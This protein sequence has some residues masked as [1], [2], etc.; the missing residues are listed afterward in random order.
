[1]GHR[2]RI[3]FRR[4]LLTKVVWWLDSSR[5]WIERW[6]AVKLGSRFLLLALTTLLL[7]G[8]PA[9][10]QPGMDCPLAVQPYSA[11]TIV[12]DLLLNPRTRAVIEK[13]APVLVHGKPGFPSMS[14]IPGFGTIINLREVAGWAAIP[15]D[16]V[17]RIDQEVRLI[18]VTRTDS[19]ER[20][21]RYDQTSPTLPKI[22]H[23]PAFLVF[24]KIVGFKDAPSVNAA[25]AALEAMAARRGWS[26]VET[27]NAAVFNKDALAN[28]DAV[29][30]NNV[31]GDVLTVPQEEAFKDYILRGG[32]FAGFHGSGGDPFYVW[33]WYA[34]TLIGARFLGHP[35][36]PQFQA[37]RVVVDDQN[38]A[39]VNGLG[40]GWTMTEEWYSFKSS[41]RSRGAHI[42]ARLDESTYSPG[43]GLIM[44]DHPI[45]WTQCLGNGR[46]FYTAIGHMP[47]N[48]SESHS[49]A[50]LEAGIAWAAGKGKTTCRL[51]QEV[52]N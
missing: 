47:E 40:S 13:Y 10:A 42:L 51:G 16:V 2:E 4:L 45:A 6:L 46:S 29:I 18:Q 14:D 24:G 27:D 35:H 25:N 23:K 52:A 5:S 1:M 41:P 48:Y 11:N 3:A 9:D 21:A 49:L 8:S 28:F 30:W 12:A 50:L 22:T 15:D 33:D 32:G 17:D 39:I 34:D 37:A 26:L 36:D 43:G 44:G 31:S 19:L 20:C 7:Q 38:D